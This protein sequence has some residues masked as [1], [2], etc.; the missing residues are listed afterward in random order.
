MADEKNQPETQLPNV[1]RGKAGPI[2]TK[3]VIDQLVLKVQ[4]SDSATS[5]DA[6]ETLKKIANGNHA[7]GKPLAQAALDKLNK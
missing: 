5:G 7:E 3:L 6:L 2:P 4:H 1:P